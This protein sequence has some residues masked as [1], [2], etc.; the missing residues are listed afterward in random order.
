MHGKLHVSQLNLVRQ[1]NYICDYYRY[2]KHMLAYLLHI[3][4]FSTY[5]WPSCIRCSAHISIFQPIFD[6]FQPIFDL[7]LTYF[8]RISYLF[9][10]LIFAA[11]FMVSTYFRPIIYL[12]VSTGLMVSE[13][14]ANR[15]PTKSPSSSK[16]QDS[17]STEEDAV[18]K[19]KV[20]KAS[21]KEVVLSSSSATHTT[22]SRTFVQMSTSSP[23]KTPTKLQTC[24]DAETPSRPHQRRSPR[25]H[26][27]SL[28]LTTPD[29]HLTP[30][31]PAVCIF[32]TSVW[33]KIE[34][35]EYCVTKYHILK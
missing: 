9:V 29:L 27:R 12:F 28:D 7:F 10:S 5:F 2:L 11:Y 22:P 33:M 31:P 19:A 15:S 3:S 1:Y 6:L 30:S 4:L 24:T 14:V 26:R 34:K 8:W 18:P 13:D 32:V 25:G 16:S 35:N 23:S 20:A 17:P 21:Q